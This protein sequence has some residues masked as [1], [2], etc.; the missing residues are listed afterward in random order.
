MS[1]SV[2]LPET[3]KAE[4]RVRPVFLPQEVVELRRL[5]SRPRVHGKFLFVG[6][7]K[8]Y[9]KGIT[10][11]AFRPNDQGIEVHDEEKIRCDFRMVAEYGFNAVRIPHTTPPR[12]LLDVAMK[13][14]LKVMVG[15][16]AEKYI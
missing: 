10:Y 14:G 9:I 13:Y 15:L 4:A 2:I 16:S 8:L 1:M 5:Q 12:N 6:N 7:E 11:G 3:T